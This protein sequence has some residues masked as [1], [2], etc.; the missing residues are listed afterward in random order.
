MGDCEEQACGPTDTCTSSACMT[1]KDG[2]RIGPELELKGQFWC[3]PK[4]GGS[5]GEHARWT[6]RQRMERQMRRDFW[7]G[8]PRAHRAEQFGHAM[9]SILEDFLPRDRECKRRIYESLIEVSYRGN[10]ALIDVR[11]EWDH[12]NKLQIEAAMV[13]SHPVWVPMDQLMP[14][15]TTS[16]SSSAK[17]ADPKENSPSESGS[18]NMDAGSDTTT[19]S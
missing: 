3:C 7:K 4:C 6:P 17:P 16:E 10:M 1:W 14:G 9:L 5:Y 19:S 12:L 8:T 11:P 18:T 15:K 2:E 13:E